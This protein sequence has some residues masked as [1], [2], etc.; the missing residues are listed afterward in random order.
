MNRGVIKRDRE[1]VELGPI[2]EGRWAGSS[3]AEVFESGGDTLMS[4]GIHEIPASET[5]VDYPPVDDVLYILE[6]EMQIV[7]EGETTSLRAGDFAYLRAGIPRTFI[8]RDRVRHVYVT[9]PSNWKRP[10]AMAE[11][12]R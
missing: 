10:D 3:I 11:V 12:P 7:S 4:A 9:Y 2:P 8:V 5:R 1:S 6:G